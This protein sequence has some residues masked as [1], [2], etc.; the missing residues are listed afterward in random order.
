[1]IKAR[2]F[3]EQL[4]AALV[5]TFGIRIPADR[6]SQYKRLKVLLDQGV[7]TRRVHSWFNAVRDTGNKAVHDGFAAQRDALL[8]VRAC[9]ELG[10]WFH[11]TVTQSPEA[12]P[13]VPPQPP[14]Q[15]AP[16]RDQADAA[17]L[18]ELKDQ[19]GSYHAELVEMRLRIDEQTTRTAAEARAQREAQAEILSA[20]REQGGLR[21][22]V[23]ELSSRVEELGRELAHRA[24]E[25]PKISTARRDALVEQAQL[26]SRPPL[27]EA[28][29]RRVIDR[30]LEQAGW[31]CRTSPP[32]TCRP[33]PGSRY[34][35]SRWPVAG[36]TTCCTS[37][38]R[39]SG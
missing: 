4:V 28:A 23:A 33:R 17:A 26:A 22:L 12:P 39:W 18:T 34:A 37:T 36:R 3:G 5:T 25:P 31:G 1:M 16:P 38:A 7:I 13:F 30:I 14:Q 35:R 8:L 32:R 27:S 15:P 24:E 21:Q 19:L 10:A 6:D 2:Q 11:R 20:L 29:V 9:Y